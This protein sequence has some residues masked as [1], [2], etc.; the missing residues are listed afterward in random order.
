MQRCRCSTTTHQL[1]LAAGEEV[2]AAAVD[3][4]VGGEEV[5]AATTASAVTSIL[6]RHHTALPPSRIRFEEGEAVGALDHPLATA[7]APRPTAPPRRSI[8]SGEGRAEGGGE[9]REGGGGRWP[10]E[11]G[12]RRPC[13][14]EEG[15]VEIEMMRRGREAPTGEG[16]RHAR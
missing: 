11:G 9:P 7:A 6:R 1:D 16:G 13:R 4:T 15:G 3:L 12:G 14:G 2:V 10:G 8:Y 5:V